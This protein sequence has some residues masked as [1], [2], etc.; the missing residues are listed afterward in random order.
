MDLLDSEYHHKIHMEQAEL[1]KQEL[2]QIINDRSLS[3]DEKE[4]KM[5]EVRAKYTELVRDTSSSTTASSSSKEDGIANKWKVSKHHSPIDSEF[6]SSEYTMETASTTKDGMSIDLSTAPK[7]FQMYRPRRSSMESTGASTIESNDA[8]TMEAI[9]SDKDRII[10]SLQRQ[11]ADLSATCITLQ[12]DGQRKDESLQELQDLYDTAEEMIAELR[13][14]KSASAPSSPVEIIASDQAPQYGPLPPFLPTLL[15]SSCGTNNPSTSATNG[16]GNS[17]KNRRFSR[18]ASNCPTFSNELRRASSVAGDINTQM[19]EEAKIEIM[20]LE[21]RLK[22]MDGEKAELLQELKTM[23]TILAET[24]ADSSQDQQQPEEKK[25]ERL[26]YQLSCRKCNVRTNFIGTTDKSLRET[27]E[28]HFDHVVRAVKGNT[29][30][31][32]SKSGSSDSDE[33]CSISSGGKQQDWATEFANHFAKHCSKKGLNKFKT[34]K[35]ED[36][37]KFCQENVK[38]E[39]LKRSDGSEL[40]WEE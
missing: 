7:S 14:Q 1:R 21:E 6:E 9:I 17:S 19:H 34:V 16:D 32:K 20:A 12:K 35:E 26:V 27:V 30:K 2:N 31:K 40:Y 33:E 36:V 18:R 10:K 24:S 22:A 8:S 5:D 23:K 29:S 39:L 15:C 28:K 37:I 11:V 25:R 3:R 38:V 4:L 13:L